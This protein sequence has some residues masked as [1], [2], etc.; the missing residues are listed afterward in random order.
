MS[1]N[2]LEHVSW[3]RSE[4]LRCLRNYFDIEVVVGLVSGAGDMETRVTPGDDI[5]IVVHALIDV[6]DISLASQTSSI[7]RGKISRAKIEGNGVPL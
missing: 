7:D 6:I 2:R 3:L 5:S 1:L 4:T